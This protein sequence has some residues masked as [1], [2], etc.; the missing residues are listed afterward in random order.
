MK[1][2]T[3]RVTELIIV[4]L[5]VYAAFLLNGYQ[6]HRQD[7]QR[8]HQILMYLEKPATSS[9]EK[10]K[11]FLVRRHHAHPQIDAFTKDI[12]PDITIKQIDELER[13]TCPFK[14][15]RIS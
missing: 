7:Q 3:G 1:N 11:L 10:L 8:R 12:M 4:F 13:Y 2:L 15:V 6:S 5:G 9:S 14:R